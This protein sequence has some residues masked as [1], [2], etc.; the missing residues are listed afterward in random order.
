MRPLTFE[1]FLRRYVRELS[2]ENTNNIYK[3]TREAVN[4]NPRLREPLL[5]YALFN[6]KEN[7]LKNAIAHSQELQK[8]FNPI[9][10]QYGSKNALRQALMADSTTLPNEYKKAYRSFQ[11][12]QNASQSDLHTKS[13]MRTKIEKL[14]KQKS[15]TNYRIYTDLH[16]NP[17]NFNDFIRNE[18]FDKMSLEKLR[19]V[20]NYLKV[21]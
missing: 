16:L 21:K 2:N 3:L 8:V 7:E 12:F 6:G 19:K 15:I 5:L 1:G 18:K 10:E 11:T 17:G 9:F 20:L 4:D 14:K 13:L